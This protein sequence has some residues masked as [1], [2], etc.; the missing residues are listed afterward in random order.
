MKNLGPRLRGDDKFL[1]PS[2]VK[3]NKRKD[4]KYAEELDGN[5]MIFGDYSA[6]GYS[7][8]RLNSHDF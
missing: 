5:Y 7:C 2:Y 4:A 8:H 1:S 3:L 6:Y